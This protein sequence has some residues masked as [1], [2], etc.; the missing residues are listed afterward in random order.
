MAP[1]RGEDVLRII[2]EDAKYRLLWDVN[3]MFYFDLTRIK[4]P[5][6]RW[7]LTVGTGFQYD[8]REYIYASLITLEQYKYE[9]GQLHYQI[10]FGVGYKLY[11]KGDW[12]LR[13]LYKIHNPPDELQ[14][15]RL[16]LGLSYRF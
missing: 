10:G 7:F 13:V 12:A 1:P 6:M 5:T 9:Y 2:G 16:T 3:F 8:R 4:R 11:I 15:N 14:T